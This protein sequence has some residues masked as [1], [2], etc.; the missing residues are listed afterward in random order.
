MSI[1]MDD[2]NKAVESGIV[3][4]V[5][6][7]FLMAECTRCYNALDF[8]T[9]ATQLQID[10]AGINDVCETTAKPYISHLKFIGDVASKAMKSTK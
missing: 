1:T 4:K 5:H 7:D 10:K 9:V 8:I 3:H 2:V 6:I